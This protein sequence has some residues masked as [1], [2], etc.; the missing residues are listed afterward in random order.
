M[1]LRDRILNEEV[2]DLTEAI[3]PDELERLASKYGA[4][5]NHFD[6]RGGSAYFDDLTSLGEFLV[7]VPESWLKKANLSRGNDGRH[8]VGWRSYR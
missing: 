3:S 5:S 1:S 4:A 6:S 2:Y 7:S 8:V